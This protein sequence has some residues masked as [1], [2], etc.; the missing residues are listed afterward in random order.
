MIQ[1]YIRL[2]LSSALRA[3]FHFSTNMLFLTMTT[4]RLKG[5]PF[6]IVRSVLSFLLSCNAQPSPV[7]YYPGGT[8]VAPDHTPCTNNEYTHCCSRAS[9]LVQWLVLGHLGH[10]LLDG[11]LHKHPLECFGMLSTRVMQDRY[12]IVF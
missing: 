1:E 8:T 5:H 10:E 4:A 6:A 2:L 12:V 11:Q 7:C 3:N 9:I